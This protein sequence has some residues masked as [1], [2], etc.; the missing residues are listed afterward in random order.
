MWR[1]SEEDVHTQYTLTSSLQNY[2]PQTVTF[3]ILSTGC[4]VAPKDILSHIL[5][6][7]HI[8]C[9]QRNVLYDIGTRIVYF[10]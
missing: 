5:E 8:K 6:N 10:V 1:N 4:W 7:F 3:K 9:E 2:R